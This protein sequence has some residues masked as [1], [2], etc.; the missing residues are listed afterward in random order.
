[1]SVV[2]RHDVIETGNERSET[3]VATSRFVFSP[4]QIIAGALGLVVAIIG[5]LATSRGGLDGSL[6]QPIV[7]TAGLHQSAMLGLIELG[8]GLL[9]ILGSLS[10][11]ARDLV[12]A[13]GFVMIIGGVVLGAGGA[14]ILRDVGTVHSTGWAIMTGGIIAV[15][16]GSLGRVV[17]SRHTVQTN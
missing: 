4:G 10:F 16:A 11:A 6:N 8:V 2:E 5:V 15:V 1:M 13:M 7:Q 17:R 14:T 12:V 9:L 3:R